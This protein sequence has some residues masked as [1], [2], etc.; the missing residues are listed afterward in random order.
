MKIIADTHT[1]TLASTH[2]YSTLLENA[3]FASE[4]GLKY[5]AVTDHAPAMQDAPHIWHFYNMK[6]LPNELYGVKIL[7][8]AEANILNEDGEIDLDEYAL[9]CLDWIVASFHGPCCKPMSIEKTT[10]AYINLAKNPKV[11]VIG[12]SGQE[13]YKYDYEKTIKIFKEYNKLVEINQNSLIVRQDSANNCVEIAKLC[14]KYNVNIVV[15]SDAHFAYSIAQV[16]DAF[17][18]LEEIDFPKNLIVN[19]DLDLFE[20]YLNNR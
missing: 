19:S 13:L 20:S 10:Q 5:L 7:K 16:N 18:M 11:D 14:K 1:H 6:I 3:K 12:H 4:I 15:N 17:K 9:Q 2:A 8:G